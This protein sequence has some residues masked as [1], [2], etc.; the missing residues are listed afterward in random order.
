MVAVQSPLLA[1][2]NG[3]KSTG[4]PASHHRP[5]RYT[6]QLDACDQRHDRAL[7]RIVASLRIWGRLPVL[8]CVQRAFVVQQRRRAVLPRKWRCHECTAHSERAFGWFVAFGASL[9][10]DVVPVPRCYAESALSTRPRP[11]D[12]SSDSQ[13]D[14][15]VMPRSRVRCAVTQRV[16]RLE[17]N[18]S[19][20]GTQHARTTSR[21]HV[22]SRARCAVRATA[23]VDVHQP[24]RP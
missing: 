5:K 21:Q 11:W 22:C 4:T 3:R 20:H 19:L 10:Q 23:L 24:R 6:S 16:V 2:T 13:R 18:R 7:A 14:A 15:K 9:P 12:V 17:P 1:L 8:A